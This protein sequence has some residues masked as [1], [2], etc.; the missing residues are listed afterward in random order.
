[1]NPLNFHLSSAQV[2]RGQASTSAE[3]KKIPQIKSL[4]PEQEAKA[5]EAI[6]DSFPNKIP[7][8]RKWIAAKKTPSEIPQA[9]TAFLQRPL[10]EKL[11]GARVFSSAERS[12]E[13]SKVI[14]NLR[15]INQSLKKMD[16]KPRKNRRCDNGH[17]GGGYL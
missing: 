6:A 5:L 14:E 7:K 11:P 17:G 3:Q 13:A 1:M 10:Q 8:A 15:S 12:V 9:F 2:L 16:K 4:K